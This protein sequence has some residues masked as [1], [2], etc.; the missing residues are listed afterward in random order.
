MIKHLLEDAR[1]FLLKVFKKMCSNYF[2]LDQWREAAI[3][4]IPRLEKWY[5]NTSLLHFQASSLRWWEEW[6]TRAFSTTLLC[7]LASTT[8]SAAPRKHQSTT[9]Y[10]I[11]LESEDNMCFHFLRCFRH[12]LEI[13]YHERSSSQWAER[14]PTPIDQFLQNCTC[15]VKVG[16]NLSPS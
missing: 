9:D 10:L 7:M 8:P 13:P 5:C 2:F 15:W 16:D 14:P 4:P 12:H 6:H 11:P 3:I 1:E